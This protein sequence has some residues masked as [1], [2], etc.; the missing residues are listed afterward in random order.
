MNRKHGH[1]E[2]D[3]R[4]PEYQSWKA[5]KARCNNPNNSKYPKYGGRG[6]KVCKK[7]QKSFAQFF[8]DMGKRPEGHTLHRIKNEGNYE[9]SNCK[10]ATRKEQNTNTSR[11]TIL[12]FGDKS[13]RVGEWEKHLGLSQSVIATRLRR[14]WTIQQALTPKTNR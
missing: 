4:S 10:W 7:W 9:P 5:M 3:E 12:T 8:K 2:K 1:A 13:M 11:N 6:I 14:G